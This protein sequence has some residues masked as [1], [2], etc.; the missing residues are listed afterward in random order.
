MRDYLRLYDEGG[1]EKL[2]EVHIYR[3]ESAPQ[4][5]YTSLEAY[6]LNKPGRAPHQ[7]VRSQDSIKQV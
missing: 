4:A 2:K 6:L 3:P 1:V 7:R 5:H